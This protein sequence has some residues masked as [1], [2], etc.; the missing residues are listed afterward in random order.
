MKNKKLLKLLNLRIRATDTRAQSGHASGVACGHRASGVGQCQAT[1]TKARD[2][3]CRCSAIRKRRRHR[4]AKIAKAS[5]AIG[6]WNVRSIKATE[7]GSQDRANGRQHLPMRARLNAAC[8][9]RK[10]R[11]QRMHHHPRPD[12]SG[13]GAAHRLGASAAGA[14]DRPGD[15]A[16][17]LR[18]AMR[19]ARQKLEAS[20]K[21]CTHLTSHVR[22]GQTTSAKGSGMSRGLHSSTVACEHR[23]GDIGVGQWHA[24]SNKAWT[25]LSRVCDP[26][27]PSPTVGSKEPRPRTHPTRLR[28]TA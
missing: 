21:A 12:A 18:D 9:I 10:R 16:A 1:G 20:A 17:G 27:A 7:I 4:H 3:R 11:G 15:I 8:N 23:L 25:H 14:R 5:L 13:Q 2:D 24:A 22:I 6:L 28:A 19:D 26:Q